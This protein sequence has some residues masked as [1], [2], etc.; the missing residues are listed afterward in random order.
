MI[1]TLE[2]LKIEQMLKN[3]H[4]KCNIRHL[5]RANGNFFR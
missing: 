1:L 3:E 5:K 4:S 2:S